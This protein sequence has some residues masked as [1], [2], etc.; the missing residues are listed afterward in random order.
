MR[1]TSDRMR[2]TLLFELIGLLICTPLASWILNKSLMQIGSLSL[3][4]SLTAMCVNYLYNLAFDLV[5]IRI[6]RPVNVRPAWLRVIHAIMF[7][8]SLIVITIPMIAW[9]LGLSLWAAFLTDLGFTLFFLVYA[10]CYN[11]IYDIAFPMPA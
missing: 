9:W 10:F 8:S 3:V 4:L 7:E 6:G 5:L 2:H 1:T 11:W